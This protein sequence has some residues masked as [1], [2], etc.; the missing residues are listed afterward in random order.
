MSKNLLVSYYHG[1]ILIHSWDIIN[2][3]LNH[4]LI[5]LFSLIL[6]TGEMAVNGDELLQKIRRPVQGI[7]AV[8]EGTLHCTVLHCTVLYCT[9]LHYLIVMKIT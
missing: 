1:H 9:T 4:H 2:F 7:R 6:L 5:S 3:N 8:S